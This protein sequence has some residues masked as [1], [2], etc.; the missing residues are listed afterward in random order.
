MRKFLQKLYLFVDK[1]LVTPIS[2]IIYFIRKKFNKSRG[3][4]DKLINKKRFLMYLSLIFAVI[5]FL[6]I[7]YKVLNLVET[8]YDVITNVPVVVTYNSTSYVVEG[9]PE[10]VDITI[11]GRSS[12][13]YLAKQLAD[14]QVQLDLTNYE[15]R[16]NGYK[17]EFKYVK[18]VDNVSYSL[19]PSY[20]TVIIKEKV[21]EVKTLSYDILNL[22]SLSP[23]LNVK[24]VTLEKNEVVV[25]GAQDVLDEISSVKALIDLSGQNLTKEGTYS[26]NDIKLVAYDND[27]K[28]MKN[29]EIVPSTITAEIELDSYSKSL[30]LNVNT[31]GS[32]VA[33]KA[34]SSI[35]ING[36]DTYALT[37][38]GDEEGLENLSS[39][40]VT[41]DVDGLG[42]NSTKTYNVTV[43]KPNGVRYIKGDTVTITV[44]F[45][46]EDQKTLDISNIKVGSK[47]LE[48]GLVS[49]V[50]N[51]DGLSVQVKGVSKVIKDITVDDISAYADVAGLKKGTHEVDVFIEDNNPL[52]SYIVSGKVTIKIS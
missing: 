31:T 4:L 23:E 41:I 21:S 11:T 27:G 51:T 2:R 25:K 45:A 20:A 5:V 47:N 7:D 16:E 3:W 40:P 49:N 1:R 43:A 9:V 28:A 36:K 52:I 34:I 35:Q 14:Y 39:I 12:D 37:V 32:L 50:V 15:P 44:T 46:D 48:N 6:L 29:V 22:D 38:Y 10:T 13:I 17:V 30:A 19:S 18:S 42:N 26:M 24:N 33:G 8:H